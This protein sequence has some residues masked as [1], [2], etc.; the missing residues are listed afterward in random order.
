MAALA[1]RS[2]KDQQQHDAEMKDLLR[3]I[4]NDKK[5]KAFMNAK[6]SDRA[7]YKTEEEAK[8]KRASFVKSLKLKMGQLLILIV[9][10]ILK[11]LML[12]LLSLSQ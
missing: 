1:D 2:E 10:Y 9:C 11:M 6:A 8:K 3:T 4:S 12:S 7:E 5:I